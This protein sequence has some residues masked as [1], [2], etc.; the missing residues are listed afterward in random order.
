M[1]RLAPGLTF[2]AGV[3]LAPPLAADS[4]EQSPGGN[5]SQ[6]VLLARLEQLE[7]T[8]AA[9]ARELAAM[10][11]RLSALPTTDPSLPP[12]SPPQAEAET[13][14]AAADTL[15]PGL[16]LPSRSSAGGELNY[17]ATDTPFQ[18]HGF[19]DLEYIDAERE[20]ARNGVSHF[21]SH[22]ANVFFDAA[23]RP[24]LRGHVELEF[25][26]A[27]DTV[28]VDQAYVR[29]GVA[30]A[31]ILQ[32]GR[33]YTPFGIERFVWYSPTNALVTRPAVYRDIVPNNF[34]A[35]G[36][37]ALGTLGERRL[38]FT[39]EAAL[40]DGLGN[41]AASNRR[42]SRQTRDNNSNRAVS[43]R[44]GV[45]LWPWLEAGASLHTQRYSTQRDLGLRFAGGDLSG[46]WRGFELRAEYVSAR[47]ERETSDPAGRPQPAPDLDQSGWYTQLSYTFER[48]REP[49]RSLALVTRYDR[50]D[51]DEAAR[52]DDDQR[53]WS[54]GGNLSIYRHFR[55]KLEYQRVRESGPVKKNDAYLGQIAFDF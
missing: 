33:F 26:H 22:H 25:E 17:G 5:P 27:G 10:R 31:I 20:G 41:A 1:K 30:R 37:T 36:L 34:Y 13:E 39:Y 23:L 8:V 52:V 50:I 7:A 16:L 46:R 28:E 21:D 4:A 48:D 2:L 54:L 55:M 9:Q 12:S 53:A 43:G 15:N 49:F 24:N 19:L 18:I 47:L 14:E 6:A 40:S 32:A 42:D 29:W 45:V 51:L 38:R 44:A 3:L 35:Q 11:E